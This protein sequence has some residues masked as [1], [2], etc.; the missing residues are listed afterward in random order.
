[1]VSSTVFGRRASSLYAG[2][3]IDTWTSLEQPGFNSPHVPGRRRLARV[4]STNE[5]GVVRGKVSFPN[6]DSK[7]TGL[8]RLAARPNLANILCA[9]T[10]VM[11]ARIESRERKATLSLVCAKIGV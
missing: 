4:F 10:T 3:T 9:P 7:S 2:T 8:L 6:L 5:R 11:P 1:M